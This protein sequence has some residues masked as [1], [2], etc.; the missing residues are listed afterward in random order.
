[1]LKSEVPCLQA[2]VNHVSKYILD[3]SMSNPKWSLGFGFFIVENTLFSLRPTFVLFSSLELHMETDCR[4]LEQTNMSLFHLWN[5]DWLDFISLWPNFLFRCCELLR[6]HHVNSFCVLQQKSMKTFSNKCLSAF[7]CL[8]WQRSSALV[9]ALTCLSA[10]LFPSAFIDTTMSSVISFSVC[11]YLSLS[12]FFALPVSPMCL[13]RHFKA[14]CV[15]LMGV[16]DF[17]QSTNIHNHS[18]S[19]PVLIKRKMSKS[20]IFQ[21]QLAYYPSLSFLNGLTREWNQRLLL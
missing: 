19:W 16:F 13:S 12:R 10:F 15:V 20:G 18:Y 4:L 7:V 17:S 11:L 14:A 8:G 3:S 5:A 2:Q 1:M 9:S 21:C 6:V